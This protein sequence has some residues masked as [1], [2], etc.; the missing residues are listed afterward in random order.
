MFIFEE[1]EEDM[2]SYM[3]HK[4][5]TSLDA[6][7]EAIRI[8][9][10]QW[11]IVLGI[12]GHDEEDVQATIQAGYEQFL[13]ELEERGIHYD[14]RHTQPREED[15]PIEVAES[16]MIGGPAIQGSISS[17]RKKDWYKIIPT[18]SGHVKFEVI[19]IPF[20]QSVM[21]HLTDSEGPTQLMFDLN[22]P[23]ENE[24]IFAQYLTKGRTYF[25]E[26]IP[27]MHGEGL[28]ITYAIRTKNL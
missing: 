27:H 18:A 9:I 7:A 23:S 25:V 21:I 12:E 20:G 1:I 14:G 11:E 4:G 8:H 19:N 16:L 28:P 22:S 2:K 6:L 24:L 3:E 17:Y 5:M 13:K 10:D 15:D 26:V